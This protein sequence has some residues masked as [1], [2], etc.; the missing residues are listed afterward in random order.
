[1]ASVI[2]LRLRARVGRL[3]TELQRQA[4]ADP[5]TGLSNRRA[6]E[7]ALRDEVAQAVAGKSPLSML[8]IDL[9]RFK[10][11]NDTWGHAAGDEVLRT[12]ADAMRTAARQDDVVARLGGD[13]FAVIVRGDSAAAARVAERIRRTLA[14]AADTPGGAPTLSIGYATVPDHASDVSSLSA[15]A[16][17]ALYEAKARGRD[18]AEAPRQRASA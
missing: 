2:I 13:E 11:V 6:F 15:A 1:M 5:L 3:L 12:V 4:L 17:A 18:R 9:D 8:A 14:A 16:D 7:L 10:Q